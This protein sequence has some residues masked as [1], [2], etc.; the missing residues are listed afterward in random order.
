MTIETHEALNR[1]LCGEVFEHEPGRAC[2][3][4]T[5]TPAMVADARGLVHGGFVFGLVDHAAMVAVNHPLVVL[6]SA[7]VRFTA[8][9]RVGDE[10]IASAQRVEEKGKKHVLEVTARVGEREVMK[11]TMVAF[12]LE[13]HVLD[14]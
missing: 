7:D 9:V 10:V 5:T 12:V 3:R 1:E 14:G 2:V 11:G 4:L 6:G 13:R 8:P